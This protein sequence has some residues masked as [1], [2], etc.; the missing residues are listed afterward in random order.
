MKPILQDVVEIDHMI[1]EAGII[2]NSCICLFAVSV[3][4]VVYRHHDGEQLLCETSPLFLW[5]VTNDKSQMWKL[6][7]HTQMRSKAC[8]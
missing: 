5:M 7:V 4:W 2:Q 3:T 1:L 6:N 8:L